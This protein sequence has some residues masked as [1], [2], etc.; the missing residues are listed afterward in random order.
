MGGQQ[1]QSSPRSPYHVPIS[2]PRHW[3]RI[4]RTPYLL[5]TGMW[6]EVAAADELLLLWS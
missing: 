5:L 3:D 6:E 2:V 4:L 1:P